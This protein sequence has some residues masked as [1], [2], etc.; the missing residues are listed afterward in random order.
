MFRYE[1]TLLDILYMS[2][3]SPKHPLTE[4]E[5]FAGTILGRAGGAS[6][7]RLR[8]LTT[9]MRERFEEVLDFTVSRMVNGDADGED[10]TEEALPRAIACFAVG[11]E[12]KS[13]FDRGIGGQLVSWKYVAAGVCLREMGRFRL[14]RI[15]GSGLLPRA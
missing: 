14:G 1:H 2:A 11:M 4:A 10:G 6:S 9:G 15:G 5:L 12:E 7:R 8:E 3:P 13:L